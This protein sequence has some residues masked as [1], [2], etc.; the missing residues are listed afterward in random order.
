MSDFSNKRHSELFV[1]AGKSL[2]VGQTIIQTLS[3]GATCTLLT[4]HLPQ[5]NHLCMHRRSAVLRSTPRGKITCV[6]NSTVVPRRARWQNWTTALIK[7]RHT[8]AGLA[9]QSVFCACRS[10]A[11]LL[12]AFTISRA[13]IFVPPWLHFSLSRARTFLHSEFWWSCKCSQ[14]DSS[15][16]CRAK[17]CPSESSQFECFISSARE[18]NVEFLLRGIHKKISTSFE[19][20]MVRSAI[21]SFCASIELQ[22]PSSAFSGLIR[23]ILLQVAHIYRALQF[24]QTNMYE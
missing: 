11:A 2:H 7:L 19:S 1:F 5:L 21:I 15:G 10:G 16:S 20:E 12:Y 13:C 22:N 17:Y 9:S 3:V 8:P 4:P 23:L 6:L 24:Q 18:K 14:G